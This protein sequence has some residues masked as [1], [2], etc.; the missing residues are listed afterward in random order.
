MNKT[1]IKTLEYLGF[2]VDRN[3][4]FQVSAKREEGAISFSVWI[5]ISYK[6]YFLELD[7]F[8]GNN[9]GKISRYN[10]TKQKDIAEYLKHN[11]R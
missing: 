5:K 1:I 8:I 3:E 6:G 4:K 9:F 7:E 11:V 2:T 10:S